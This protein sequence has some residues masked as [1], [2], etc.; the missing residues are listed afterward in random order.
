MICCCAAPR[1]PS[2]S[3]SP[4]ESG[5]GAWRRRGRAQ[6]KAPRST[7]QPPTSTACSGRPPA[8][9]SEC[10]L[11]ATVD[12]PAGAIAP[13]SSRV[14]FPFRPSPAG[15][16]LGPRAQVV[17][18]G[19]VQSHLA[20][21]P[22]LPVTS[23]RPPTPPRPFGASSRRDA[24]HPLPTTR[25]SPPCA[26]V[27]YHP[28]LSTASAAYLRPP[29]LC[30]CD[31]VSAVAPEACCC[32]RCCRVRH[33]ASRLVTAAFSRS[34][35]L[36]TPRERRSAVPASSRHAVSVRILR[37]DASTLIDQLGEK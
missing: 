23:P 26:P 22:L 35:S 17:Q 3:P 25:R 20:E 36:Y 5:S 2:P 8:L 6:G 34:V 27:A 7:P 21:A 32:A 10:H 33:R 12:G 14:T 15:A 37:G 30:S 19:R 29:P 18:R 4:S 13:D 1:T 16:H 31:A 11:T 28:P 9:A 24:P